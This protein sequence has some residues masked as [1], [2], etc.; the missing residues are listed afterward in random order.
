MTPQTNDVLAQRLDGLDRKVDSLDSSMRE[1]IDEFR[2]DI[3][4]DIEH[5]SNAIGSLSFVDQRVHDIEVASL[6]EQ[7][8]LI[9]RQLRERADTL[10]ALVA[11]GEERRALNFRMAVGALGSSLL[12]PLLVGLVL[13][14]VTQGGSP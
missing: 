2:S 3:K 9:D 5:L 1:R 11:A 6:R 14:A 13:W 12:L 10:E 8:H 7:V 4:E